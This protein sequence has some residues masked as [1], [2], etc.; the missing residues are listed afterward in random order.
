MAAPVSVMAVTI[1]PA[2]S[3]VIRMHAADNVVVA[4]VDL[5]QGASAEGIACLN[6]IP[7]GHKV[8]VAPI[9]QGEAVRRFKVSAAKNGDFK[10]TVQ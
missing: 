6:R 9:A 3:P 7:A 4:R 2:A 1:C 10:Y 5:P 8:A